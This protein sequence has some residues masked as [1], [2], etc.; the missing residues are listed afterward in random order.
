MEKN[1]RNLLSKRDLRHLAILDTLLNKKNITIK[2][3]SENLKTQSKTISLDI[4][5]INNYISPAR[6][7]VSYD[8]VSLIMPDT[9]S[10]RYI[11]N[12]VLVQSREIGII[13]QI[14]FNKNKTIEKHAKQFYLS[15]IT[16]RRTIDCINNKLSGLKL[17]INTKKMKLEGEN[18]DLLQLMTFIISEKYYSTNCYLL[19]KQAAVLDDLLKEVIPNKNF[20]FPDLEKLR[21]WLFLKIELIKKSEAQFPSSI[22]NKYNLHCSAKIKEQFLSVFGVELIDDHICYLFEQFLRDRYAFNYEGLI[23]IFEE[24]EDKREFYS[25][26]ERMIDEISKSFN[27]ECINRE[28]LVVDLFNISNMCTMDPFIIYNRKKQF[29]D[30]MPYSLEPIVNHL[31]KIIKKY[32]GKAIKEYQIN[33]IVYIIFT[34]WPKFVTSITKSIEQITIGVFYDND[35]EHTN[36][37][38]TA[39]SDVL[40][41]EV[42]VLIPREINLEEISKVLDGIDLL[43]TNIPNIYS[44][45][46]K[47]LCTEDFP[48][49]LEWSKLKRK[50]LDIYNKRIALLI[51]CNHQEV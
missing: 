32:F 1:V 40:P 44:K 43:V 3:L 12:Q 23:N 46:N 16:L 8:G 48:S 19:P 9:V 31:I 35:I 4:K 27:I 17:K 36:L 20:N 51:K 37:I 50:I 6:I 11:Y 38:C 45:E 39:I 33:E 30:N 28:E 49:S 2:T 13:E 7:E 14:F 10:S 42:K 5:D 26:L 15:E 34:H 18:Q 24:R 22:S 21:L 25:N 47:V 29:V 41:I